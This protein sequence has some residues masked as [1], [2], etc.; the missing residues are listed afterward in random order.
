ML[1]TYT[2]VLFVNANKQEVI[3]KFVGYESQS[4][5]VGLVVLTSVLIGMV[6]CAALCSVELLSLY[7]QR[8]SLRKKIHQLANRV[9][10]PQ[11][12]TP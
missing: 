12:V 10:Q 7:M 8:N 2:G 5:P 9:E 6:A 3:V 11:Q 4:V 1:F